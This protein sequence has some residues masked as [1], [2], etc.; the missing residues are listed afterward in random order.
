M[1]VAEQAYQQ[2]I[3]KVTIGFSTGK[4]SLVGIDLLQKA[5]IEF[6]PI[7][8][9]VVP[10]L[11]FIEN[12]IKKYEDHFKMKVVRLP[13]PILYDYINHQD[14]QPF[15]RALTMSET[16]LGVISFKLLTEMYLLSKQIK[17]F[18]YDC[19]C[20]KMA[21]SINRR[22]LMRNKP[23]IN[24]VTKTIYLTKY[25]T[26]NQCFEYLKKNNIPLTDDYRIFGRSW[27]GLSYHFTMGVK[28]Y[29][30]E[31]YELIKSYWPLIDA[32]VMRYKIVSRNE[33][34]R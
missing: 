21:D 7:Y 22:L 27:D 4:D 26:N 11:K 15:D 14:W 3:K 13:H 25:F 6:I 18:D 10:G 8:F 34:I 29:Y 2:G 32:E 24:K 23:D 12:N 30:P 9:Y 17:G 20:M 28:K 5:G 16:A 1:T 19:N 33:Y 31:D